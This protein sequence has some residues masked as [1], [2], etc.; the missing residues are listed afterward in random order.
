M[1]VVPGIIIFLSLIYPDSFSFGGHQLQ[2]K[3]SNLATESPENSLQY[4]MSAKNIQHDGKLC[5]YTKMCS[6]FQNFVSPASALLFFTPSR[7]ISSSYR[8][9]RCIGNTL[10]PCS[11]ALANDI[12]PL[13]RSL[14]PL[15]T[16]ALLEAPHSK[17]FRNRFNYIFLERHGCCAI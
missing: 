16:L 15:L 10:R 1:L 5:S 9:L 11:A 7:T 6:Y 3:I 2:L 4:P 17:R 14:I 8:W 13:Y 12:Q